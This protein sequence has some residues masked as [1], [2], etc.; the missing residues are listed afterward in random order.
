MQCH[1]EVLGISH[2]AD[3][4]TIKK[5]HRKKAIQC[6]PDKNLEDPDTAVE[7]FRLVQEAYE[8]LS[9][10]SERQWYDDHRDALLKGW[11]AGSNNADDDSVRHCFNVL[12][13]MHAHCYTGYNDNDDDDKSFYKIY[14]H[15]FASIAKEENDAIENN[16]NNSTTNGS[17]HKHNNTM[18]LP[19]DFGNS[20]T[21]LQ[22]V[23]IFYQTWEGF[24][25][26]LTF[27]WADHY[28]TFRDGTVDRRTRRAM[29]DENKKA[30]RTARKA[31][32][33]DI[34]TLVTFVKRRDPRMQAW[35]QQHE[36]AQLERTRQLLETKMRKKQEAALARHEWRQQAELELAQAE[37]MDR[38]LGRIR[39]A[40]LEQDEDDSYEYA[41]KKKRKGKKKNKGRT[42]NQ[43][44]E[45]E[46][47]QQEQQ[48]QQ[49][50]DAQQETE[51][52][53]T[54]QLKN[55]A[56]ND[57]EKDESLPQQFSTN[58]DDDGEVHHPVDDNS[59]NCSASS[60]STAAEDD[61]EEEEEPDFWRCDC[62]KKDFKSQGQLD[63]HMNSKKHKD[64]YKK[65]QKKMEEQS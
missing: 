7:S 41:G 28:D 56:D 31:R 46:E 60:S 59:N 18:L 61:E 42:N 52:T 48:Q 54:E 43:E 4:T 58:N 2:D 15:V 38:L 19:H 13:Y 62:C 16:S 17:K 11:T 65:Y 10:P 47:E 32:T 37:E 35:K 9:D 45:E 36:V 63:N 39:L 55:N 23:A 49:D 20:T 12:P 14:G 34:V 53:P 6:H 44:Q 40:D 5:A 1:Y 29:E 24:V 27:A 25:S 21:P 30:R 3:A 8:C 57:Q 26:S 51:Q 50:D 64:A 33:S 22:D